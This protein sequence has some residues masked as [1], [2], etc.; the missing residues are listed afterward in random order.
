MNLLD[1]YLV[2]KVSRRGE[3]LIEPSSNNTN[4]KLQL[5]E[6]EAEEGTCEF[7]IHIH[8]DIYIYR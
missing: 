8:I 4:Q 6:G 5:L 3:L 2:L 1:R 7:P